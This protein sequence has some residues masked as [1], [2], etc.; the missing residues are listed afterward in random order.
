VAGIVCIDTLSYI[1]LC[2]SSRGFGTDNS[3]CKWVLQVVSYDV[4]C[5]FSYVRVSSDLGYGVTVVKARTGTL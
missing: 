4:V 2:V 5:F 1:L 3:K